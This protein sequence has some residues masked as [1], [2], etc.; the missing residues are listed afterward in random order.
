MYQVKTIIFLFIGVCV[1]NAATPEIITINDVIGEEIAIS[2]DT[3]AHLD[4]GFSIPLTYGL[5]ISGLNSGAPYQVYM[6]VSAGDDWEPMMPAPVDTLYHY[7]ECFRMDEDIRMLLV[8]AAFHHES[9]SLFIK[10]HD[11]DGMPVTLRF[12]E[13]CPFYDNRQTG[14]V[15]SLDDMAGWSRTKFQRAI[16][17]IRSYGIWSTCGINTNGCNASMYAFIQSQLDTGFVEASAHSRSHPAARPYDDYEGEIAGC[18]NDLIENLDMPASYAAG[19]REYV[20]TWIAPNGYTDAV[21]DSIVG[22]EKYL[23][24]RLYRSDVFGFSEWDDEN[25]SFFPLGVARAFDPPREVLG[26]GIGSDD[27]DD[28]NAGFDQAL[29]E[30]ELYH[31]MCHPNVVEWDKSYPEE[32]LAYIS[33]RENVWYTSVGHAFLYHF[34]QTGY[35]TEATSIVVADH[36][37]PDHL[38]LVTNYPNPFNPSTTIEFSLRQPAD[39]HVDIFDARGRHLERL[40]DTRMSSGVHT[41]KWDAGQFA[42]G[43]YFYQIQSEGTLKRGRMLLIR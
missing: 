19:D 38:E 36:R 40:A 24:N 7:L 39:V 34:A 8:S 9:D 13:I 2:V 15:C 25:G 23:V 28:L 33:G 41:L 3:Q 11:K 32:H 42:S 18:K 1:L 6:R 29:G 10:C 31:V 14:V 20:Y 22:R 4:Y 30:G 12:S 16:R 5:K 21:V 37:Q 17:I 35:T 43:I 26:W 27:I